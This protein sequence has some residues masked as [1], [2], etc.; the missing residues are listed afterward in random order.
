LSVGLLQLTLANYGQRL[1]SF[2]EA[3]D[4]SF[5]RLVMQ[6]IL[7]PIFQIPAVVDLIASSRQGFLF[8]DT[9]AKF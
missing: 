1:Q 4:G 5:Y 2:P 7:D 8:G 9:R 6:M 3:V